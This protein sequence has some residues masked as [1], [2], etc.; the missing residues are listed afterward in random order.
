MEDINQ[1]YKFLTYNHME[2]RLDEF[3]T[4]ST[5]PQM[6]MLDMDQHLFYETELT[7]PAE[8]RID[9]FTKMEETFGPLE[10]LPHDFMVADVYGLLFHERHKP[11]F[12]TLKQKD[13]ILHPAI[14]IG[15]REG[16]NDAIFEGY[17][18]IASPHRPLSWVDLEKS[19][20]ILKEGG[21]RDSESK[22]EKIKKLRSLELKQS[23]ANIPLEKRMFF[24]IAEMD[25]SST[26][27]YISEPLVLNSIAEYIAQ[28]DTTEQILFLTTEQVQEDPGILYN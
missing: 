23:I 24:N 13:I 3:K 2:S 9:Y 11:F 19:K 25:D 28:H 6:W 8:F 26:H 20:V 10:T 4:L 21:L 7:R 1:A 22:P 12:R 18:L 16:S 17:Y 14:L 5:T 15:E 27:T